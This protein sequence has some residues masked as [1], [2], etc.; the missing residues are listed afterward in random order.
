MVGTFFAWARSRSRTVRTNTSTTP[1]T[2]PRPTPHSCT[3]RAPSKSPASTGSTRAREPPPSTDGVE[4]A[5]A[6]RYCD[7]LTDLSRGR[8]WEHFVF[9]SHR[10]R[11]SLL[12]RLGGVQARDAYLGPLIGRRTC[13]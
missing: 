5:G 7:G 1:A 12:V 11:Q 9:F 3:K 8:L 10:K 6:Q 13:Q 4:L 2:L